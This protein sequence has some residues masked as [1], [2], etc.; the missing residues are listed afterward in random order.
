MEAEITSSQ[1]YFGTVPVIQ[2]SESPGP[3]GDYALSQRVGRRSRRSNSVDSLYAEDSTSDGGTS[4]D[5]RLVSRKLFR[6]TNVREE[7]FDDF[8]RRRRNLLEKE[9]STI[10]L[11]TSPV[12]VLTYFLAYMLY[13]FKSALEYA[14]SRKWIIVSIPIIR[15]I[16]SLIFWYSYWIGLGI[17]SSVGLGTGLHT[18]VLFLGPHIAEVTWVAFECGNL[19]FE[20]RGPNRFRCKTAVLASTY[21]SLF[22]IFRKV[23][24]ESFFWGLGTAIGELPPYFVARAAALSGSRSQELEMID[25]LMTQSP[26]KISIKEKV[27][28]NVNRMMQR[29]GFWGILLFASIPNPLF[30]L[31]GIICGQFLVPFSTFFGA[32]FLGKAVIK[33]S[34]QTFIVILAFSQETLATILEATKEY[35]PSVHDKIAKAVYE[36]TRILKRGEGVSAPDDGPAN[37]SYISLVWNTFFNLMLAYFALSIIETLAVAH[38]TR[39][40]E[41]EIEK[42]EK[43]VHKREADA[44]RKKEER[45]QTLMTLSAMGDDRNK[46]DRDYIRGYSRQSQLVACR[47]NQNNCELE[48]CRLNDFHR[49]N[50]CQMIEYH[51]YCLRNPLGSSFELAI[52][53]VIL[54]IPPNWHDNKVQSITL[55]FDLLN[56]QGLYEFKSN[57]LLSGKVNP[58]QK[59][60][61]NSIQRKAKSIIAD[62]R[63]YTVT[64]KPVTPPN[65][66]KHEFYTLAP[67]FHSDCSNIIQVTDPERQCPFVR[68]DGVFIKP[69]GRI[70]DGMDSVGM[71]DDVLV[72]AIGFALFENQEYVKKA[73]QLLAVW[74]LDPRTQMLPRVNYGQV[75]RGPGEWKG[76]PEG[77]LDIRF[78]VYIPFVVEILKTAPNWNPSITDGLRTW[79]GQLAQWM[80]TSELGL[81]E[82]KAKNNHGTFF[83][84]Q[85][86]T[87]LHFSGQV[88]KAK[89]IITNFVNGPYQDQIEANGEQRRE[90]KR[91]HPY[92]Y[93]CFNLFAL[94]YIARFS[95]RIGG[96]DVW[97]TKTL[98]GGDIRTAIDYIMDTLQPTNKAEATDLIIP[99]YSTEMRY[100]Y[101]SDR[102]ARKLSE[103]LTPGRGLDMYWV[104]WSPK[105]LENVPF[106]NNKF[107]SIIP[108][109]IN[110]FQFQKTPS[111]KLNQYL[112]KHLNFLTFWERCGG[113]GGGGG[114]GGNNR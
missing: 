111:N 15:G 36:Q 57:Y 109:G 61:L 8:I 4:D 59:A 82:Q 105:S 12:L 28:L 95:D 52:S 10:S 46:G 103:F 98:K 1:N 34:I 45:A 67:Y 27:L 101:V 9:R 73:A 41:Q 110:R 11:Y 69:D 99:L 84:A 58:V 113:G 64:Y 112:F 72:L 6:K 70:T 19:D 107:H 21:V 90:L 5:G 42:L 56:P 91:T 65:G 20:T 87:Y 37:P 38:L 55:K 18:F 47:E 14:R 102:Y 16:Q 63:A 114:G 32:T 66:N 89:Q 79:F 48:Y 30:D 29:L 85:L 50:I 43:R 83:A 17:A 77:I 33:S 23:Q 35:L 78:F 26:E 94:T 81:R 104:L 92:H 2:I 25:T 54:D 49:Q 39:V 3:T 108:E 24:W 7:S 97:S 80:E 53:N 44:K 96:P 13:Q 88:D 22:R 100:S 71:V 93:S 75:V 60:I 68:K 106:P 40:H 51:V 62:P 86:S 76:R 31:A 74:F